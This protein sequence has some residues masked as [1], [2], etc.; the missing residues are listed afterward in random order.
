[1]ANEVSNDYT[2]GRFLMYWGDAYSRGSFQNIKGTYGYYTW[3]DGVRNSG[4]VTGKNQGFYVQDSWRPSPTLTLNL[5]VRFENEFL[6]P[7][8]AEVNGV[9]VANPVSF[10]WGDKIAP[11]LGF[12]WDMKGDG[13]WKLSGNFGIYYDVLKYELARGSF[14]SDNW[15]THVY[16]LNDPDIT[17]LGFKANPGA[18]G[19]EI[20]GL[21]QPHSPHQR[22]GRDRGHRPRHQALPEPRVHGR[23]RSPVRRAVHGGHPL[24]APRPAPGHRGHRRPRR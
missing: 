11:R 22:R 8:K 5:G 21:R 19:S 24:H 2:D 3:E 16:T 10:G 13:R 4:A 9:A 12:A 23:A 17:K 20:T 15:F 7:Y 6:P 14:G 1:M 18:L